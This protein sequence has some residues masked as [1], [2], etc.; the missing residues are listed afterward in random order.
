M[1]LGVCCVWW[2]VRLERASQGIGGSEQSAERKT[3]G[4][5]KA[6]A[7]PMRVCDLVRFDLHLLVIEHAMCLFRE[8]MRLDSKTRRKNKV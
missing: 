6:H 5:F 2:S 8:A 3:P 7:P 1:P 4:F